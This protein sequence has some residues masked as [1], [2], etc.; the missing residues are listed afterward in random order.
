MASMAARASRAWSGRASKTLRPEPAWIAMMPVLCATKSCSSRAIRSRSAI[1]AWAAAWARTS[2]ARACACRIECPMSQ[3]MIMKR[4]T[5]IVAT[6]IADDP[7][8][9]PRSEPREGTARSGISSPA[10][11]MAA[12]VTETLRVLVAAT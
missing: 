4:G 12:P 8:P 7:T 11:A 2:S 10:K 5:A 1:V 9:P 3:A 6:C